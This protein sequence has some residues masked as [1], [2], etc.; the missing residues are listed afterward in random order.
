MSSF[1][2]SGAVGIL[3]GYDDADARTEG[4]S[5]RV[6]DGIV[7]AIGAVTP[8]ADERVVD[9]SGA[10]VTPGLIN[11]HHHLFQSVMKAVPAGLNQPLF[12]WLRTVP[13]HYWH[14]LDEEALRV[15]ATI[16]MVELILSG[17]TTITD[18][19]YICSERYDYDPA[20]VLFDVADRLGTRFLLEQITSQNRFGFDW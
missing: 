1:L 7:T 2:I 18:H 19:H 4:G 8:R 3:T 14:R 15:S 10:V 6:E 17:A 11:T 13:F 9:A 5:V 12:T 16:G 20:A